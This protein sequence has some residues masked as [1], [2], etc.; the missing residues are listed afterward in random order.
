MSAGDY[1]GPFALLLGGLV[2]VHELGHFLV[3]KALGVKVER[4]S[5]GIGPALI[6]RRF[7]E[8][9][10]QLA[11][12]PLGGY[13]KMLG[14]IPGEPLPEAEAARSFN[15]QAVWKRVAIALAGPGMNF[16]LPVVLLGA[17]YWVGMPSPTSRIGAV[18]PGSPA[19]EAGLRPGDR[20]V[21][22]AGEPV[23]SWQDLTAAW[24]E[25]AGGPVPLEIERSGTRLQVEI[26]AEPFDALGI[27]H[28]ARSATVAVLS[29]EMPAGRAG[30]QTGDRI[31]RVNATPVESWEE[32][33][34]ALATAAGPLE[35]EVERRLPEG[36]RAHVILKIASPPRR[37]SPTALGLTPAGLEIATVDPESPAGRAGLEPGD[38]LRSVDGAPIQS[39]QSLAVRVRASRGRSLQLQVLRDGELRTV[40][41][42]PEQRVL[43]RRGRAERVF[44]IGVGGVPVARVPGESVLEVAHN[45]F[46]ALARG[47]A[48]TWDITVST[49]AGLGMLVAGQVGRESLAG[50]I[51]I[52]KLAADFFQLGWLPFVHIMA[53]ISV[54]LAILNLLPVPILDGGQIVFA[55]AE[56]MKGEP[57]SLRVREIAAQV[58]VSLLVLLMAFAFWNDLSRYWSSIVDY[59]QGLV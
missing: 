51:G 18:L 22:V 32:A 8:T 25:P 6:H 35:L 37:P 7:G 39:F 45:P 11:W 29:P 3:A 16:L 31:V 19:A 2:F 36:E 59:F 15:G 20:V 12:L 30:V 33:S 53:I 57:L 54:N 50:P 38:L 13:V 14:E 21:R 41:V 43:E 42:A 34:A 24:E 58:G 26:A 40:S 55:L 56:G 5:I 28:D 47:A 1:L 52:G 44:A 17:A 9:D 10:Y 4:F 48:R 46:V 27:E 49:F 23:A